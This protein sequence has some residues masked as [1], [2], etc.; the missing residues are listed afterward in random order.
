MEV[1]HRDY[2]GERADREVGQLVGGGERERLLG[3]VEIGDDGEGRDQ[4]AEK[5]ER[6]GLSVDVGDLMGDVVVENVEKTFESIE[7]YSAIL[8]IITQITPIN[9]RDVS[10]S[11]K[12]FREL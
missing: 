10:I 5:L 9:G 1:K 7:K 2:A 4:I 8:A 3:G 12:S 11:F 6:V